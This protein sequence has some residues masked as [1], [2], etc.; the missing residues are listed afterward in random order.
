MEPSGLYVFVASGYELGFK[1]GSF[2]GQR[3]EAG[4]ALRPKAGRRA[5][6]GPFPAALVS[7]GPPFCSRTALLHSLSFCHCLWLEKTRAWPI[8]SPTGGVSRFGGMG[9]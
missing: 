1:P 9:G 3:L 4:P 5:L 8:L 2:W 6:P 7:P